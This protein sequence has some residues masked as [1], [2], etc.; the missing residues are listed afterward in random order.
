MKLPK[1][2]A[3]GHW[4]IY[5]WAVQNLTQP[6]DWVFDPTVGTGTA[7]VEAMNNGR[8]GIG[9]ELEFPEIAK[10]NI[11]FQ[12]Q[13]TGKGIL[14][15]GNAKLIQKNLFSEGIGYDSLSLIING[16]PYP[17][18]GS[19][20]S[21]APER[22]NLSTKED[23]SFDYMHQDNFGK[24]SGDE[25]W[26]FI[27]QMY[28]DCIPFMKIGGKMVIAVKD[29]IKN[30]QPYLLHKEIVDRL[31]KKTTQLK[32]V[33]CVIHLHAPPTLFISTYGKRFKGVKIPKYQ[34]G[35][36]LERVK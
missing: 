27:T 6:G 10:G 1:H 35:I 17:T 19:K 7:I 3:P 21:D 18:E 12:K 5:R 11:A 26:D 36:I 32:Y 34:T 31:L 8:N 2:I 23:H 15:H 29:L 30:K 20:S 22:K 16:T 9:I 33:G 28:L 24:K 14:I 25:Y 13:A 4:Q